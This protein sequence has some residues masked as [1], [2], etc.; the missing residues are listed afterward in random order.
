MSGDETSRLVATLDVGQIPV[1]ANLLVHTHV[2]T[3][4]GNLDPTNPFMTVG[5]SDGAF[6]NG[7]SFID[8]FVGA[9]VTVR[10]I[11]NLFAPGSPGENWYAA[12]VAPEDLTYI[13]EF[14]YVET[15]FTGYAPTASLIASI[16]NNGPANPF[17]GGNAANYMDVILYYYVVEL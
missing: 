14:D 9:T 4:Y 10:N 5:W 6:E 13:N 12:P 15:H 7:F 16:I 8:D 2:V 17:N 11:T 1:F 3:A